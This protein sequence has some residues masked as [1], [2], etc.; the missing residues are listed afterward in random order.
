MISSKKELKYFLLCDKIALKINKKQ[1]FPIPLVNNIWKYEILLRKC[2]YHKNTKHKFRYLLYKLRLLKLGEKL[3][4]KIDPNVF[5]PG[6][7]IAH[8]GS[9]IVNP[10]SKVGNNCRI[11]EGVTIGATNGSS[12]APQIGDNCFIGSGAKI[13]GD[14]KI[15]N[16]VA[17]G[18]GAV[19][20]KDIDDNV[21]V[22]GVPAKVISHN[23]SANNIV[24]AVEMVSNL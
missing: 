16:N 8:Y 13:I 1:K 19:V 5:G 6:L 12:K 20:V 11:H 9:I 15:G 17:I 2:E 18:A 7:S 21:T 23:N 14:I 10:N 4:I 24:N 3:T 22:G